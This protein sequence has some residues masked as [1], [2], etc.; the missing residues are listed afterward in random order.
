MPKENLKNDPYT[1]GTKCVIVAGSIPRRKMLGGYR[2]PPNFH[3]S[4][5]MQTPSPSNNYSNL[6][7]EIPLNVYPGP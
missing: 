7:I 6:H 1:S 3:V 4:P 5:P 2:T